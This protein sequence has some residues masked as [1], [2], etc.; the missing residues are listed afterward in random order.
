MELLDK[1]YGASIRFT[2]REIVIEVK[3]TQQ[4]GKEWGA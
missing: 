2:V 3:T 4:R 1:S